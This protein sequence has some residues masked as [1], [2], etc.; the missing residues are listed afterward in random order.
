MQSW[1]EMTEV[2]EE[3]ILK[4]IHNDDRHGME[5]MKKRAASLV[6][7]QPPREEW[8]KPDTQMFFKKLDIR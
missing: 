1:D 2:G 8:P 5:T 4:I 3:F 6:E 7:A